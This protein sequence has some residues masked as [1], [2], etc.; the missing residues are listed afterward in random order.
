MDGTCST[1]GFYARSDA[2][3]NPFTVDATNGYFGEV[4]G[5]YYNTGIV[6]GIGAVSGEQYWELSSYCLPP[7]YNG[8]DYYSPEGYNS[9]LPLSNDHHASV[10]DQHN[11]FSVSSVS[12]LHGD[13]SHQVSNYS[14]ESR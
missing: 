14:L 10:A 12:S 7:V 5:L 1:G 6:E 3:M 2:I 8:V 4:E 9:T 13:I 11:G